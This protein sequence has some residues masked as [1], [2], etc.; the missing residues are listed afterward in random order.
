MR[1]KSYKVRDCKS[2]KTCSYK[3]I[4]KSKASKSG[5]NKKDSSSRKSIFKRVVD[6]KL[7][8]FYYPIKKEGIEKGIFVLIPEKRGYS[9]YLRY[10]ELLL[11]T[12]KSKYAKMLR[13]MW[14][15]E[16]AK[17]QRKYKVILKNKYKNTQFEKYVEAMSHRVGDPL[18]VMYNDTLS[19]LYDIWKSMKIPTHKLLNAQSDDSSTDEYSDDSDTDEYSEDSD[20]YTEDYSSSKIKPKPHVAAKVAAKSA[21]LKKLPL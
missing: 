5:R 16:G 20:E 10:S 4:M 17:A 2:S 9:L 7:M 19:E 3:A 6:Y 18:K 15:N 8:D 14:Y 1:T 13:S 12:L 11:T 21:F